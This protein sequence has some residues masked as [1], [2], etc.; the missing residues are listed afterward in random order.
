MTRRIIAGSVAR[1]RHCPGAT[2]RRRHSPL[3]AF[4]AIA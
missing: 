1:M 2:R 4:A 3:R